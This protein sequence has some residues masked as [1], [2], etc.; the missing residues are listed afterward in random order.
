MNQKSRRLGNYLYFIIASV[1]LFGVGVCLSSFETSE[2]NAVILDMQRIFPAQ[3]GDLVQK[4]LETG[5]VNSFSKLNIRSKLGGRIA[6]IY[7]G[8]GDSV[9]QGEYLL[10]LDDK[11]ARS[12]LNQAKAN[13]ERCR[14]EI[15]QAEVRLEYAR[16]NWLNCWRLFNKGLIARYELEQA[17]RDYDLLKT[18]LYASCSNEKYHKEVYST[19]LIELKD[20]VI[21]S[22]ISGVVIERLVEEGEII[23]PISQVLLVIGDLSRMHIKTDINE[24]DI[25]RVKEG[26]Y[27]KIRFDAICNRFYD[28]QVTEVS[29]AGKKQGNI[30]TYE[31]KIKI[32]NADNQIKPEMSCDID[33]VT[34]KAEN[35]IYMPIEAVEEK[36]GKCFVMVKKEERFILQEVI[37][38]LANDNYIA[39]KEGVKE[40]QEVKYL[41][42]PKGQKERECLSRKRS[43]KDFR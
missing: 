36:D 37:P 14:A 9:R 7:V 28:G 30:V 33:L 12:R 23:A 3:R 11:D 4:I 13:L 32:L 34:G 31:V 21:K 22:P 24:I 43:G 2:D 42:S 27:A 39:I 19:S 1:F 29:P 8:K 16:T 26:Q 5:T 15:E 20:T 35:V 18:Q 17:K 38:G 6:S 10:R 25:N 40:G 41:S